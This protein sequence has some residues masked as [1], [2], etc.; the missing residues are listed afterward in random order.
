MSP[1]T[2]PD[3]AAFWS[4]FIYAH[5]S[6]AN[7]PFPKAE[8]FGSGVEMGDELCALIVEGKKTATCSCLWEWQAEGEDIPRVGELSIL[9]GGHNNPRAVIEVTEVTVRPYGEVDAAFAF[10]EG[11]DDRTLESWRRIHWQWFSNGLPAIGRAPSMEMP[12]VCKRFRVRY[13]E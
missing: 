6:A 11:E 7:T 5:P 4:R 12:L 13:A 10:E 3:V 9:L 1:S 8:Q 2:N